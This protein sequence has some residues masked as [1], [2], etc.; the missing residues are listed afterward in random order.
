MKTHLAVLA[1]LAFAAFIAAPARAQAPATASPQLSEGAKKLQAISQQLNLTP[2]QKKKLLPVLEAEAPKIKALKEDTSLPPRQ[3]LQQM[4]AIHQESDGQI[5][6]I[7]TTDQYTKWQ[8]IRQQ[9]I[10]EM[11]AKRR[12]AQ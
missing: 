4:H 1:A 11:I 9:E 12:A 7:L 5:K 2:E 8:A 3:K 10:Q 6:N